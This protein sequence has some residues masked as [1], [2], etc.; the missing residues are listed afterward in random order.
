MLCRKL[1]WNFTFSNQN[2]KPTSYVTWK[3]FK[4]KNSISKLN[5]FLVNCAS[6]CTL[7]VILLEV[8]INMYQYWKC[9]GWDLILRWKWV[10]WML[11]GK[12]VGNVSSLTRGLLFVTFHLFF[13]ALNELNL[14]QNLKVSEETHSLLLLWNWIK[15]VG[16]NGR[17]MTPWRVK[18]GIWG[19]TLG[20]FVKGDSQSVL[21]QLKWSKESILKQSRQWH[22]MF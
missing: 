4:R 12:L 18:E 13:M 7:C 11:R 8:T 20:Q 14:K 15:Q 1:E 5:G 2:Q 6:F 10:G 21:L 16:T 22:L 3:S 9:I 17:V 19:V